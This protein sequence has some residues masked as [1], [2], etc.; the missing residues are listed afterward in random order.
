LPQ[1]SRHCAPAHPDIGLGQHPKAP[2]GR[3]H[4]REDPGGVVGRTVVDDNDNDLDLGHVLR[5][6]RPERP[7]QGGRRVFGCRKGA[8]AGCRDAALPMRL[9]LP[10]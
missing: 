3:C 4:L 1:R 9:N 8:E 6:H 2:V 7:F 10:A 5:Q